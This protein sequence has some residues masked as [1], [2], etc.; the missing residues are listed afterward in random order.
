MKPQPPQQVW[1]SCDSALWYTCE[2]AAD[3]MAGRRPGITLDVV[4]PFPPDAQ[5]QPSGASGDFALYELRANGDGSYLRNQGFFFATGAL[6]L[7]ATAA[8]AMG[9]AAGNNAR[10]RAAI[11]ATTPRWTAIDG[12]HLYLACSGFKMHSATGLF[13][14]AYSDVDSAQMV[15]PQCVSFQGLSSRGPI[16]WVVSSMWAEL[17]FITWALARHPRHPQVVSGG[18]LPP[19]WLQRCKTYGQHTRLATAALAS[20]GFSSPSAH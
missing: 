15:A 9:R 8:I 6:G 19:G 4:A 5:N 7:A 12:G 10:R 3:L 17:L 11:E 2:I 18:W 20:S 13:P 14:W 1:D 16:S